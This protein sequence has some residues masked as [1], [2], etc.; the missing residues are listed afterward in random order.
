MPYKIAAVLGSTYLGSFIDHVS[1]VHL[2]SPPLTISLR[3]A[4]RIDR[5]NYRY[6]LSV[7]IAGHWPI[8]WEPVIPQCLCMSTHTCQD[9][10]SLSAARRSLPVCHIYTFMWW[11]PTLL[12]LWLV[13]S[14]KPCYEIFYIMAPQV[15][16]IMLL[17]LNFT[18]IKW[19][20]LLMIILGKLVFF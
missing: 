3:G 19:T 12:Q 14:N 18:F 4:N 15:S 1:E 2:V 16:D 10:T 6:Y 9:H 20:F 13:V 7:V 5:M 8:L 11:Q 17:H